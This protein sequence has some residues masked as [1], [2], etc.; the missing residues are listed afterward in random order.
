[1]N[2][3]FFFATILVFCLLLSCREAAPTQTENTPI[4]T[5]TDD[6][7]STLAYQDASLSPAERADDLLSRMT[8]AE[9]IGQM[10][11]VEKNSLGNGAIGEWG[12]GALLSGGGGY[13]QPNTA[14]SWAKNIR[15]Y[16]DEALSTRLGIPLLYGS[17]AVHGHGNL[18]GA[19]IFPHNIGLGA[20][21]DADLLE[22]IGQ[23]TA[24]ETAVSG[25]NWN[26]APVLAVPQDIRWGRTY[27]AYSEN[28]AVVTKLATAYLR[29]LQGDD[30]ASSETVLATPKHFV[31]DGGTA[32]GSSTTALFMDKQYVYQIDQGVTEVDEETLRTVH[33]SP[34]QAAID[35]GARSIMVSFSS[36]G[37]MK[38]HAQRYLLTD[39]LKGEM[40][41]T[42][43]VVSDWAG[44][45]Q[46]SD[47]YEAA[48]VTAVNAG[49]DMNMVPTDY[50][51]FINILTKAVENGDVPQERIDDAVRRILTVKFEM[52]LFENPSP[53]DNFFEQVGS[54][55]HRALAREA[56]SKSVVLLKND[57]HIVPL[58]KDAQ[59]I[60]V[61]GKAADDIGI[62]S[63]GWTIEWQGA[64]GNI[65]NG[66]TILEG[67]EQAV[68]AETAVTYNSF[69]KFDRITDD[70]GNLAIADYGIVVVGE[71]P[72]AEGLGDQAD[73]SLSEADL[74][75]I[76]RVRER[77]EKLVV[78]I[79]SGR[80]LI[81][82]EPL[83]DWDAALAVWLPGTEANGIA[84]V[85]FGDVSF[86][87]ILPFT[88][89]RTM[90][91]LPFDFNNM[92][93]RGCGAALFP[94]GYGLSTDSMETAVL[95][96]PDQ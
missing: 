92:P 21:H 61:A 75:V 38:M 73:L 11:L 27:E 14:E 42:G 71:T 68:G 91:Q 80:P 41:F 74:T 67:I 18:K 87:G 13:F 3:R 60:F 69:G 78:L 55:D 19:V 59:R 37:G 49:I 56:V 29:G 47:D 33:L 43:F 72:Y 64:I 15:A 51:R 95:C 28:T 36:W 93:S 17:D 44:I 46:I 82:T 6:A 23:V 89:P 83:R 79:V 10:T 30:L 70:N 63:G 26:F 45:D 54:A 52:G 25:V 35:A 22:R 4:D 81:I 31:G 32:W 9:K 57:G 94:F 53:D 88:W 12:L 39:V 90:S 84:D 65:S 7:T 62:Q 40:G 77:S 50:N 5:I 2:R 20:T 34:Y 16:Q 96:P 8:L 66:T 76:E 58:P 86:Q 85:L 1:M 24:V 48:V